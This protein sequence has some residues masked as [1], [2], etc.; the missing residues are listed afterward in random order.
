MIENQLKLIARGVDEEN[1][2]F[3][4]DA[5]YYLPILRKQADTFEKLKNVIYLPLYLNKRYL[6]HY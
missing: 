2:Q 6:F 1:L 4:K 3:I 5:L